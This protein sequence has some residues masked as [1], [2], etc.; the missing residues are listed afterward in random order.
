MA[1]KR[2]GTLEMWQRLATTE[3]EPIHLGA[4]L[5]DF[6]EWALPYILIKDED[7]DWAAW[8]AIEGLES[9]CHTDDFP[10]H[11]KRPVQFLITKPLQKAQTY[12]SPPR[13]AAY[14]TVSLL[15]WQDAYSLLD[16]VD[17]LEDDFCT[18]LGV[19]VASL[20]HGVRECVGGGD[21]CAPHAVHYGH[22][23]HFGWKPLPDRVK[24]YVLGM[25]VAK[26]RPASSTGIRF[27]GGKS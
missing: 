14:R 8:H 3:V 22:T 25:V 7:T 1:N 23:L 19:Y 21:V 4:T 18:P 27:G 20:L 16:K 15:V 26:E 13:S 17:F 5:P 12:P 6:I 9:V 11:A 10:H 24:R 2:V